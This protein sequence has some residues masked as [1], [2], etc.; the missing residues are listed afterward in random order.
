MVSK[1]KLSDQIMFIIARTNSVAGNRKSARFRFS[2]FMCM[3]NVIAR[4]A[5]TMARSS[6]RMKTRDCS[7]F[8]YAIRICRAEMMRMVAYTKR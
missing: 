1:R 7:T 5:C 2:D 4:P 3:K 8:E 6:M